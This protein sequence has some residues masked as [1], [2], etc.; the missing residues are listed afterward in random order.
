VSPDGILESRS[1]F[2]SSLVSLFA[3]SGTLVCCALPAL[4]VALGAGAALSSLIAVF[5]QIVWLS[6]HKE[7]VFALAGAMTLLGGIMQ[8]RNRTAPCP[9]DPKL[10]AA[11][12][13]TR[14]AS[15]RVFGLSVFMYLVGGWFAFVLPWLRS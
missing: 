12:L 8:W 3:S 11:C 9:A 7:T 1:G 13:K 6:E 14:R 2:W 5:P 4:L 10:S 15:L